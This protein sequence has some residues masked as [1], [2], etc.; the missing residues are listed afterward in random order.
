MCITAVDVIPVP[1]PPRVSPAGDA[2]KLNVQPS[3]E[4]HVQYHTGPATSFYSVLAPGG[5]SA[6]PAQTKALFA[7]V[8]TQGP[9]VAGFAPRASVNGCSLANGPSAGPPPSTE[10]TTPCEPEREEL[11]PGDEVPELC[12]ESPGDEVPELCSESSDILTMETA[13]LPDGEL[14]VTFDDAEAA[15]EPLDFLLANLWTQK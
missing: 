3:S 14:P 1:A 7:D 5:S 8:L 10:S 6:L 15:G 12:S 2:V 13:R 4:Y 11:R 9:Q